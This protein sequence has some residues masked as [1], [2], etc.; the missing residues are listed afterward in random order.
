M[1]EVDQIKAI[2]RDGQT[3]VQKLH[4]LLDMAN[5]NLSN[6]QQAIRVIEE[7][8]E[9]GWTYEI[10]RRVLGA[11]GTASVTRSEWDLMFPPVR[12]RLRADTLNTLAQ[13][14]R[15]FRDIRS[16]IEAEL[17]DRAAGLGRSGRVIQEVNAEQRPRL[18]APS[19]PPQ[20]SP[21]WHAVASCLLP[22]LGTI[23]CGRTKRGLLF[24]G[25]SAFF[26]IGVN[27]LA[28]ALIAGQPT[29]LGTFLAL[30]VWIWGMI[31][32]HR[33]AQQW[34][35]EHVRQVSDRGHTATDPELRPRANPAPDVEIRP[36]PQWFPDPFGRHQHR[37]WDG[38]RW[39]E[40]AA[41]GGVACVDPVPAHLPP[42][43]EHEPLIAASEDRDDAARQDAAEALSKIG[44]SGAVDTRP[45]DFGQ[46]VGG[47]AQA[48]AE[49]EDIAP[50]TR[51]AAELSDEY[52]GRGHPMDATMQMLGMKRTKPIYKV[53]RNK[54]GRESQPH[55]DM[56]IVSVASCLPSDE[57]DMNDTAKIAELA[58]VAIEHYASIPK[59]LA[60][61]L[62]PYKL[63]VRPWVKGATIPPEA[64]CSVYSG[65]ENLLLE[66]YEELPAGGTI[67][68]E[69]VGQKIDQLI[70]SVD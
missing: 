35:R 22:G 23:L 4:E 7:A 48:V 17:A 38:S 12:V 27:L 14:Q 45:V 31:D 25:L 33:S 64:I 43:E 9:G 32:G 61:F 34:N 62:L 46:N 53:V 50:K 3:S 70:K 51:R 52:I 1:N 6:S 69:V 65:V 29:G 68:D 54:V 28:D 67:T 30:P 63:R 26:L 39:S 5:E 44:D 58:L 37:Y 57:V 41:D 16:A 66:V 49:Y 20:K 18:Q 8:G 24:F 15:V 21:G 40:N 47:K 13:A 2:A 42:Q 10:W 19:R 60:F 36:G 56:M 11:G 59:V 55:I